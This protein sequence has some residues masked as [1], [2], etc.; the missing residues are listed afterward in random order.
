M[1]IS[2]AVPTTLGPN[3]SLYGQHVVDQRGGVDDQVDGVGQPLPGLL[4]QAEVGL[5][6][7][8]GDDLQMVGGQ[9]PVVAQQLGIA[10]VERLVQPFAGRGVV[11]GAH[12]ADQLA[13]DEVHPLQPFQG[14]EAAEES[15]RAGQQ[16]GADFGARRGQ[17]S[18]RR[19]ASCRR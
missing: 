16:D 17:T 11:L 18:G 4:I 12:Q 7:V 2:S 5:A 14:Q 3:S 15:G 1:R 9:F 10:A 13:V 6:L 8:A 19:P